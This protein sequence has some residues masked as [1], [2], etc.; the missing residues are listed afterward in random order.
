MIFVI[1]SEIAVR[2]K[3]IRGFNMFETGKRMCQ[4]VFILENGFL[5]PVL[6]PVI[7]LWG[8]NLRQISLVIHVTCIK[9]SYLISKVRWYMVLPG[10]EAILALYFR[11]W[12]FGPHFGAGNK[13]FGVPIEATYATVKCNLQ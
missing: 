11:K 1:I 6:G 4:K 12:V 8:S 9:V 10:L 5:G 2:S 13:D 3:N 7:R